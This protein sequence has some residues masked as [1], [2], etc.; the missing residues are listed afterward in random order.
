[1]RT[2]FGCHRMTVYS[3]RYVFDP[4]IA[5]GIDDTKNRPARL[6]ARTGVVTLRARIEGH[7]VLTTHFMDDLDDPFALD[8]NHDRCRG[9]TRHASR[10]SGTAA[11][12]HERG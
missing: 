9:N 11:H 10:R 6:I 3:R 2:D 8:V 5:P 1:M 7:L 4:V 12:Q